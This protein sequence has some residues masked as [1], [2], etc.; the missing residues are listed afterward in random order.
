MEEEAVKTVEAG[1]RALVEAEVDKLLDR[2]SE[3]A[4]AGGMHAS[5]DPGATAY[6][7]PLHGLPR[8]HHVNVIVAR[9]PPA[10]YGS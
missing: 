6:G 4:R 5:E 8:D 9:F 3:R 1:L 7:A 10:Q 2:Y